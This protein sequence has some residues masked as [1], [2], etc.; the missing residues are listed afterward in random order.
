M[1]NIF[2]CELCNK[3]FKSINSLSKH[4]CN[5][6][7]NLDRKNYYD[8]YIKSADEGIC[9]NCRKSTSYINLI[10]GYDTLCKECRFALSHTRICE[11]CNNTFIS[12]DSRSI[13]CDN[14]KCKKLLGHIKYK[15]NIVECICKNCNLTYN[16]TTKQSKEYCS[17]CIKKI[18]PINYKNKVIQKRCCHYCKK[19]LITVEKNVTRKIPEYLYILTCDECKQLLRKQYSDKMKLNNPSYEHPL[20]LDEYNIK[21]KEKEYY[22]SEEYKLQKSKETKEYLSNRMKENN[23]MYNKCTRKKVGDTLKRKYKNGQ[24]RKHYGKDHW[25]YTGTR[26]ING[27]IRLCL[28][29]WRKS[30]LIRTDY[31]CEYCHIRGGTLHIHHIIPLREIIN[32]GINEL[33]LNVDELEF[34][35]DNYQKLE[36]WILKYHNEHNIGLV[37]CR[38]CHAKIDEKYFAPKKLYEENSDEIIK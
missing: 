35:N 36:N 26:S 34:R 16:A 25:N 15:N 21:Q 10:Q 5:N 38:K 7:K 19:V 18:K 6:H 30:N 20:T 27:Y 22:N 8:T 32:I 28:G 24:I 4:M 33:N 13:C 11:I 1:N 37:V 29:D 2:K 14:P 9:E 17:K 23:P 12:R 31:T 3:E